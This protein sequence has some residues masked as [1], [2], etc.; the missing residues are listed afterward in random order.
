MIAT[1]SSQRSGFAPSK[2]CYFAP[3]ICSEP[4]R[5][6]ASQPRASSGAFF[7]A[8]A[9]RSRGVLGGSKKKPRRSGASDTFFRRIWT[10]L[11]DSGELLG[12][13]HI[14]LVGMISHRPLSG[15]DG[16]HIFAHSSKPL[17]PP[18]ALCECRH[19][20]LARHR[21]AV[22]WRAVP[23]DARRPMSTSTALLPARRVP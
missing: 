10:T 18:P 23:R 9:P 13:V 22:R 4:N 16:H 11:G 15:C 20:V 14:A 7:A 8:Q 5:T 12:A 21:I 17:F 3:N 2:T 1:L 19:R 6:C